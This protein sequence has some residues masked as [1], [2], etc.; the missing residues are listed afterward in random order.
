MKAAFAAP[1]FPPADIDAFRTDRGSEFANSEIDDLPE[2]FDIRRPLSRRG[3]PYDSAAIGSTD[4]IPKKSS[5]IGGRSPTSAGSA[6]SPTHTFGG[7]TR[8]GCIRRQAT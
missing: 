4:G 8:S 3:N 7:T 1:G 2:A 6:T 5:S